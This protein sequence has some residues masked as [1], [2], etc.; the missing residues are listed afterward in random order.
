MIL[1]LA[2][3]LL[4]EQFKAG[5]GE[6]FRLRGI[7]VACLAGLAYYARDATRVFAGKAG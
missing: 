4:L 5:T 6:Y 2:F 7:Q 3:R 1:Y